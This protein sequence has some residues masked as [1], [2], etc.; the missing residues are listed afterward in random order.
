MRNMDR[1]SEN[2]IQPNELEVLTFHEIPHIPPKE[3]LQGTTEYL[4]H[5]RSLVTQELSQQAARQMGTD[6]QTVFS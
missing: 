5:M 3:I 6:M 1:P 4:L 2:I